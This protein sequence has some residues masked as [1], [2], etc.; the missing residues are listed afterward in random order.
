M[1]TLSPHILRLRVVI[2]AALLLT[3]IHTCASATLAGDDDAMNEQFE[4]LAERFIDESPA[5]SPVS[6]T[7]LGDHRFDHELDQVSKEARERRRTFLS[8]FLA[9][10][11]QIDRAQ[12]TRDNQ[13]DYAFLRHELHKQLWRLDRLEEWAWNPVVYTQLAGSAIYG[14]TA[15]EFAPA[16]ERLAAVTSRLEQFPRLYEQIR[17]TLVPARVPRVHAETAAKQN[18]GVLSIID[19]AVRPL[20][21]ELNEDEK[22]RLEQAI[23]LAT[24]AVQQHQ[25]WLDDELVPAAEGDFRLGP[26]LYDEKLRFTLEGSLSRQEVRERAEFELRRVRA[27]MYEIARDVLKD[28]RTELALPDEPTREQQQQAIAAAIELAAADRPPRDGIVAAA[29]HSMEIATRFVREHD[30]ITIPDDPMTIIIMPEF[31]RGVSVAYCDSPGPLEVGQQTYYAVAPLPEDWTDEQC[32]SFLREYN[33][34]S[35]HNLTVHEAMPGHFLQLARSNRCPSRLRALL[36]SGVFVEGWA[37]YTE[38]MMSEQGFLDRDPLMRLVTLKWY[39]RTIS[40]AILDQSI[41]FD[42]IRRDEAMKLMMEDAFQ[43]EREAA[44]KWTRAQLTSTQLSTYFVGVQQHFDLR[45]AA[46]EQWGDDFSLKRYNDAVTAHGS[47]PVRF[48]RSLVLDEPIPE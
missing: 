31:Q 47:P 14:L 20:M 8:D 21:D 1:N 6:A 37:C 41:H 44:G 33:I 2:V 40:N 36:S 45:E 46:R 32:T 18:D 3:I 34:R 17:Q 29:E 42:G 7:T 28:G 26:E 15:R 10:V 30:L 48:V 5:L 43:E 35:I 13:V 38:Q 24:E 25:T 16:G 9:D 11:E 23:E 4:A 12:L 27:E 22:A 39:L 19:N